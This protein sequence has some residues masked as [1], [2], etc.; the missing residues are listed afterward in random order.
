[1]SGA[2]GVE[3]VV[4]WRIVRGL[5]DLRE[6]E[7]IVR[8]R[9]VRGEQCYHV[10]LEPEGTNKARR[11]DLS[12]ITRNRDGS[13]VHKVVTAIGRRAVTSHR[14]NRRWENGGYTVVYGM[15]AC[16]GARSVTPWSVCLPRTGTQ[17]EARTGLP[18]TRAN[19]CEWVM[20]TVRCE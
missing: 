5:G 3:R 11:R 19:G 4:R 18:P 2:R 20:R 14:G 1:M 6:D 15:H 13:R 9:I 10:L 12:R 8:W 17:A 7:R 16:E